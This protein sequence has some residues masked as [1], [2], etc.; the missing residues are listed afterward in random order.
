MEGSI[1]L[2]S[3][4]SAFLRF[5]NTDY[6]AAK[7]GIFGFMR[8]L[9]PVLADHPGDIRI[10]CVMPSW[11]RTG[12]LPEK[13]FEDLGYGHLLQD[14]E[15]VARSAVLLMADNK[16]HGQNIYSR[17]GKFW[18]VE[19]LYMKLGRDIVGEDDEDTVSICS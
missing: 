15:A 3:S 1:V 14:S 9:V 7:N 12:M 13:T 6:L 16:R 19:N 2:I 17:Q 5:R 11:T 10:N 4:A 18:E 8:G